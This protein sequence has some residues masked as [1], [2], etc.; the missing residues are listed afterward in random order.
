MITEAVS[1]VNLTSLKRINSVEII[2]NNPFIR[3]N[4]SLNPFIF[5]NDDQLSFNHRFNFFINFI[6][7]LIFE[8]YFYHLF[9]PTG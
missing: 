5:T 1:A 6:M 4:N 9:S 8:R 2:D 3:N 7:G